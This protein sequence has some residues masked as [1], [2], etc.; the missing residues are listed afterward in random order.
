[1]PQATNFQRLFCRWRFESEEKIHNVA[2][3]FS[4]NQ[5]RHNMILCDQ[6]QI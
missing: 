6:R 5:Y 4:L 2:F 1:M 3:K